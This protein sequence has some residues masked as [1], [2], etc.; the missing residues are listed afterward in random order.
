[1]AE[2]VLGGADGESA[3]LRGQGPVFVVGPMGSGTT[4]MRLVLDSH[5]RLALAPETG[6]ARLIL[7]HEQVP[8]WKFGERVVRPARPDARRAR[9]RAEGVLRR[10]VRA[11]RR[12]TRS[13]ALGRQD[14][15]PHLARATA[16]QG[17]PGRRLRRDRTAPRRCR[18]VVAGTVRLHLAGRRP[19]LGAVDD[20]AGLPRLGAR[21]PLPAVPLRG[22]GRRSGATAARA[23]RLARRAVGGAGARLPRGAP[24]PRHRRGGRRPHPLRPADGHQPDRPLDE[25]RRGAGARAAAPADRRRWPHCSATTSRCRRRRGRCGPACPASGCSPPARTSRLCGAATTASTG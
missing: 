20:R 21:R 24:R 1:M 23:V 4:L 13:R 22:P 7:A 18:A 2:P 9:R 6:L 14:A 10:A 12:A 8:F 17:V 11:V 25:R 16:G 3:S 15:V 5:S 19:A